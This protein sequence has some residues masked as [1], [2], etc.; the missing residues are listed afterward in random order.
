MT[1]TPGAPEDRLSRIEEILNRAARLT[2]Q[3]TQAIAGLEANA[4]RHDEAL[5]RLE[6]S[7]ARHEETLTRNEAAIA[8]L[9]EATTRHDEA[10]SKNEEVLARLLE[11][12]SWNMESVTRHGETL[13]QLEVNVAR[14]EENFLRFEGAII[15]LANRMDRNERG[16]EALRTTAAET[17][18]LVAEQARLHAQHTANIEEIWRYLQ[19]EPRNGNGRSDQNS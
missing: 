18:Q 14:H 4:A 17:L 11:V 6:A 16:I 7:S 13:S 9:L 2:L 19:Y 12:T 15:D 10:I 8:Q 3:N 1:Q 5:S